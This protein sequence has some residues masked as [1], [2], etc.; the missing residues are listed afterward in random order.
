MTNQPAQLDTSIKVVTPE[1]IA[2]SYRVAGPTRR[3]VAFLIDLGIRLAVVML[4]FMAVA[5]IAMSTS[6]FL[7]NWMTGLAVAGVTVFLFLLEWFYGALFETFMNGRTPGKMMM[8][9]RVLTIEG[10]PINGLQAVVRNLLRFADL[11]PLLS[12]EVLAVPVPVYMIP[13]GLVG[14]AVMAMNPRFQ[15]LGDLVCGTMVVVEERHALTGV[16]RLEDPRAAQLASLLPANYVVNRR[17]ARAVNNYVERRRHFSFARRREVA[18]HL[19]EPLLA[20]F[21]LPADTSYDLLLCALYYRAFIAD[22]GDD[23]RFIGP[24]TPINVPAS[25]EKQGDIVFL[26]PGQ[27]YG[28]PGAEQRE[29]APMR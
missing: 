17:M 6:A 8:G 26:P 9:L 23:A 3:L 4:L 13:T 22:R 2:F 16:T 11:M 12:L 28:P 14:L 25:A 20:P 15:R 19:A 7:G 10:E 5:F 1:N 27:L 18:A 24:P 21:G 29:T